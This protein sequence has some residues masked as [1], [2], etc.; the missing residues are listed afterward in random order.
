MAEIEAKMTEKWKALRENDDIY[1]KRHRNN[2]RERKEKWRKSFYYEMKI[3]TAKIEMAE[4]GASIMKKMAKE[5]VEINRRRHIGGYEIESKSKPRKCSWKESATKIENRYDEIEEMFPRNEEGKRRKRESR[6]NTK[7]PINHAG[8][9]A[10]VEIGEEENIVWRNERN[11][12]IRN[13]Q[14]KSHLHI[15]LRPRRKIEN[16]EEN[17]NRNGNISKIIRN[18]KSRSENQSAD[19]KRKSK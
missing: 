12:E 18:E 10:T 2:P 9:M 1:E 15:N 6:W 7:F 5:N 19:Q 17:E 8:V 4:K 3:I 14:M 16:E 13:N 11:E